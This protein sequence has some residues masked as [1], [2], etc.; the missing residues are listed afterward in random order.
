LSKIYFA[1]RREGAKNPAEPEKGVS[2]EDTKM[3]RQ[4][5]STAR[6]LRAFV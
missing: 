3:V 2:H 6:H 5:V 1:Q 4:A